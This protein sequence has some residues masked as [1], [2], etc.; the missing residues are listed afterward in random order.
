MA[1]RKRKLKSGIPLEANHLDLFNKSSELGT[2][3][4]CFFNNKGGVGK[5]TLVANLAAELAINFGAKILLVDGDPQCNLTQHVLGE[6]E[7][8]SIYAS[9]NPNGIY[10]VIRSVEYVQGYG[11]LLPIRRAENFQCDIIIGDPRLALQE[12][13]LA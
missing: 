3:S 8:L 4:T 6:E 12:D 9:K 10:S 13:L 2:T 5:T 7:S 11:K 1:L